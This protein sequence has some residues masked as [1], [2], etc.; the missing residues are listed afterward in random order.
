MPGQGSRGRQGRA[1]FVRVGWRQCQ[2]GMPCM[3]LPVP[4]RDA[5][6]GH[7]EAHAHSHTYT[8]S[9]RTWAPLSTHWE[10]LHGMWQRHSSLLPTLGFRTRACLFI[11]QQERA[12]R[13]GRSQCRRM[14]V[15][16]PDICMCSGLLS[17]KKKVG[18]VEIT[19]SAN[20]EVDI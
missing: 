12:Q 5:Y 20:I 10:R 2:M 6:K 14:P 13:K 19:F 1:G 8:H 17:K 16:Y 18:F 7:T 9:L 11:G 4:G 3:V 15:L